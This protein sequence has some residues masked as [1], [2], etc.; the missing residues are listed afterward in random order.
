MDHV[1]PRMSPLRI[2]TKGLPW[3]K[4]WWIWVKTTRKWI[5]D[6]DWYFYIESRGISVVIKK[7]FVFDGASIPKFLR[8]FFSPVGILL[9]PGILHDFGY[10][11]R[12]LLRVNDITGETCKTWE[13]FARWDWDMLFRDVAIQVNGFKILNRAARSALIIFGGF[14]WRR[15]RKNDIKTGENNESD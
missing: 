2:K 7:G 12:F 11:N 9:L 4:A 15:H 6:E 1:M 8:M 3:V 5:L 10:K 13:S 14:A